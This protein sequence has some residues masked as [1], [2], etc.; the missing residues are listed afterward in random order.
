MFVLSA[1]AIASVWSSA[2]AADF[3]R[4]NSATSGF[5]KA[6]MKSGSLS[7]LK[8]TMATQGRKMIE[9]GYYWDEVYGGDASCDTGILNEVW[10]TILGQC[11]YHDY[12]SS[13][14]GN[15]LSCAKT[16]SNIEMILAYYELSN[17]CVGGGLPD[18]QRNFAGGD[19]C[20]YG[21]NSAGGNVANK[22]N[23]NDDHNTYYKY[24]GL[25][26]LYY[27]SIAIDD[28]QADD[29][30]Q[31]TET[32]DETMASCMNGDRPTYFHTVPNNGCVNAWDSNAPDQVTAGLI[33][34]YT[35]SVGAHNPPYW[36]KF[37]C[38][39]DKAGFTT[40]TAQNYADN[41]CTTAPS[42]VI[43]RWSSVDDAG[44]VYSNPQLQ[45]CTG[46]TDTNGNNIKN[47][48]RLACITE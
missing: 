7:E 3:K 34:M 39:V 43:D 44:T 29:D 37:S 27:E 1:L 31:K 20:I 14:G 38:S 6:A 8:T 48:Y 28:M 36:W 40:I 22:R 41:L 5:N 45:Q 10:G 4:S 33:N 17:T 26:Q 32:V 16:S 12:D 9:E 15:I 30:N 19:H 13:D 23:C 11:Y 35:S 46:I 2:S 21:L 42:T 25:S 47:A 24:A 18:I